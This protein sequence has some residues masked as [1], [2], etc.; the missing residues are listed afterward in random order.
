ME[1]DS[2]IE[3]VLSYADD[4]NESTPRFELYVKTQVRLQRTCCSLSFSVKPPISMRPF[5]TILRAEFW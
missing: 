2:N 4:T 5:Q 3:E 1:V